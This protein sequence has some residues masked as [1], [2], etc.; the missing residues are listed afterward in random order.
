MVRGSF[1]CYVLPV[2]RKARENL[3]AARLLLDQENP[4]T[5]AA[6]SRA[7]YAT[8]QALW[9]S[10][11]GT[12]EQVPEVRPGRRYFPHRRSESD[13]SIMDAAERCHILSANEANEVKILRDFR[14]QADYQADDVVEQDARKCLDTAD[15]IV[16]RLVEPEGA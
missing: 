16:Q 7:Y 9:A 10:L 13:E 6:A 4:C 8:Y 12:G 2:D 1:P 15:V 5:N 3:E 14:I 11:V